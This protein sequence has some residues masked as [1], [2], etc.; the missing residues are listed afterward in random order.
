MAHDDD[1]KGKGDIGDRGS[2]GS[3]EKGERGSGIGGIWDGHRGD[4]NNNSDRGSKNDGWITRPTTSETPI[5]PT[6]QTSDED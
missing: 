3:I 4:Y 2:K 6:Q 5:Q 1:K